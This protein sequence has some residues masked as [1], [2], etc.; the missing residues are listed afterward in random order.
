MRIPFYKYQA[1]AND[2]IIINQMIVPY[3]TNPEE[4]L[5]EQWCDRRLGIGADGLM[6][7]TPSDIANFKMAY[8]NS[9]GRESTMCGNGGRA[10][11][12]LAYNLK[13]IQAET[14]FEAID[15]LHEAKINGDQVEL[16]MIDVDQINESSEAYILDTGS[17]HY[18]QFKE[19]VELMDI[20]AEAKKI[21]YSD[22]F[23]IEGINVNF[24]QE[25]KGSLRVRTYERGVEDETY[26]CGT[27]V[28]AAGLAYLINKNQHNGSYEVKINTKG[29]NLS[30][31]VEKENNSFKNIW[32]I[33]PAYQV[34]E[35]QI[36]LNL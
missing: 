21:R 30:V 11:A 18:V 33:G 9:D 12:H 5:I 17:P 8:Y 31:K 16:K 22:L 35:G 1:T 13:L 3:L 7:I 19:D 29:G 15:G 20:I 25:V 32:L 6:L 34:F 23:K 28:T 10:I 36:D 24:V 4:E 27:G 26:S 14:T 2:F